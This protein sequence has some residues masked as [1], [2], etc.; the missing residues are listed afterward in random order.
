MDAS[1]SEEEQPKAKQRKSIAS[2]P[3]KAARS[4]K[5]NKAS[6]TK[7]TKQYAHLL[8]ETPTVSNDRL[9]ENLQRQ[10]QELIQM[11]Q[12]THRKTTSA[13]QDEIEELRAE[14]R[15]PS[16]GVIKWVCYLY[17]QS[18]YCY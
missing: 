11:M 9:L 15:D 10:H 12:A 6:P 2:T 7:L 5:Q 14:I 17:D 1:E 4:K 16:V 3:K 8:A 18:A 13:L